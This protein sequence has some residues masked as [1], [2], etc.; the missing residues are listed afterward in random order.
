MVIN[1]DNNYDNDLLP[2]GLYSPML[3]KGCVRVFQNGEVSLWISIVPI[4][5]PIILSIIDLDF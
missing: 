5:V 4:T 3:N 1:Y 2:Q